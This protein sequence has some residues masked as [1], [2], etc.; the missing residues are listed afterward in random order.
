[1]LGRSITNAMGTL[2]ASG[3]RSTLTINELQYLLGMA[4]T[5]A[6]AATAV[7]AVAPQGID[8]FSATVMGVI[9]A[10]GGGTFAT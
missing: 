3:D 9:T 5:V 2:P 10:I 7:A 6:F 4:G 1:M 8:F